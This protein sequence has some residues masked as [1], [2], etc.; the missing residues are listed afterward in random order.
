MADDAKTRNG[1]QAK[2]KSSVLLGNWSRG[3][4]MTVKS[5]ETSE[6]SKL[7][8]QSAIKD[9]W[10]LCNGVK[11]NGIHTKSTEFSRELA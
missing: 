8:S 5:V 10:L 2:M 4:S 6:R 7:V 3:E 1:V 9:T 11:P